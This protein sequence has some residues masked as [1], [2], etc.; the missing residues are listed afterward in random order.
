[1]K[2]ATKDKRIQYPEA[3]KNERI[4]TILGVPLQAKGAIACALRIYTSRPRAFKKEEIQFLTAIAEVG[5][6][7]IQNAQLHQRLLEEEKELKFGWSGW[8]EGS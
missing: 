3:A 8:F 4:A 5:T 6:L 2:D 1:V 7:A